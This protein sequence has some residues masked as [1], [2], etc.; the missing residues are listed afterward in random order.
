MDIDHPVDLVSFLR[1]S[2]RVPTRT[3]GFLE[4]SGIAG[5]LLAANQDLR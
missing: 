2:P 5:R 4:E 3:L 1:M